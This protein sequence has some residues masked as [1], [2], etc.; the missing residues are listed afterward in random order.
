MRHLARI[1]NDLARMSVSLK[2]VNEIIDSPKESDTEGAAPHQLNGRIIFE[3]ATF[4]YDQNKPVLQNLSFSIN[5]GETAAFLGST[6]SGKSTILHLLLRL[7]DYN[8]GSITINGHELRT[9]SKSWLREKI[10]IVLQEPFLFSKSIIENIRMARADSRLEDVHE[11]A[12]TSA[13]HDVIEGFEHGYDTLVG[14]KGI[15]LSGGQKQRVAMARTLIKNSDILIFD[16]SLSAVD[17]ETD[18]QIR[19]ELKKRRAGVTTILISQRITTLM[20]ADRIFILERGRLADSGTHEELISRDGLY[21]RIWK[22][23]NMIE[24]D[25]NEEIKSPSA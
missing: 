6:G 17:T 13:V 20:E 8:S 24:D 7:Y 23:Q 14:E 10:G 3:N 2:R 18:S 15:T 1:L 22:I 12:R 5:T 11:A 19:S 21:S 9:I 25:F 16:D 4:S